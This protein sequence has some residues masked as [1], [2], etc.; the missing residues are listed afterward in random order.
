MATPTALKTELQEPR[1]TLG[2]DGQRYPGSPPPGPPTGTSDTPCSR[3]R[4]W[5]SFGVAPLAIR[6]LSGQPA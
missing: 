4:P 1:H 6:G 2:A 3:S 5:D